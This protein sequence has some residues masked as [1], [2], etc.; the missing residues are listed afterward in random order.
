M[1]LAVL[2]SLACR[3]ETPQPPPVVTT[4]S[5]EG[6]NREGGRLVRRLEGDVRTLNYLLQQTEDERQ[7]L[8]FLYDPLIEFDQNLMP[9]PGTAARWEVLDGGKTYVLHLDPRANFSDG[10][11]VRASDVVFTLNKIFDARVDAVRAVVRRTRPRADESHRRAHGS[12][13]LQGTARRTQLLSFNIGVLP[14][15]VYAKGDFEKTA[16]LV[17]NGPYVLKQ[18]ERDRSILLERRENYWREKPHID[19][20]LFR[21]I[22]D[23]AVAC[24][25]LQRGDIDVS[26]VDNDIWFRVK[27]EPAVKEKSSFHN[28]WQFGYNVHRLEPRRSA[29]CKTRACAARWRWLRPADRD[30]QAL[31]RAGARG[32][33]AVHARSARR[34]TRRCTAIEFNPH[35]RRGAALLRR[36][37][38]TATTTASSIANGKKFEL[39]AA[40]HRRQRSRR[41][42]VADL[43]GRAGEASACKLEI[44]RSTKRRFSISYCSAISRRR[45]WPGSTS[46]I[47]IRRLFHST[48]MR[49]GRDERHRLQERRGRSTHGRG[50][51][52]LDPARRI[53]LYHQLHEVLARDQPYLW[54]VQVADEVGGEPARAERAAWPTDYGLFLW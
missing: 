43:S 53:E 38:A 34:T 23:D 2:L 29:A 21:P 25:A 36:M 37:D 41:A 39:H 14:E 17:G 35:G 31:P 32:D 9:I 3:R 1:V 51:A 15:H 44:S 8:A 33:R 18:R 42:T 45:S 16:K 22:A 40:R 12:R 4:T 46:P 48:Q 52:E 11:P 20:V 24:E 13:R 6:V 27:D 47:P 54:M 26:R 10:T 30:R 19:S 28:V 50:R 5:A 7:V 49:A